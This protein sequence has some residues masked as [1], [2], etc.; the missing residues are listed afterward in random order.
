MLLISCVSD[1]VKV[2]LCIISPPSTAKCIS[3]AGQDP[4][5]QL[6]CKGEGTAEVLAKQRPSIFGSGNIK[7]TLLKVYFITDMN[8][9]HLLA[10]S[11]NEILICDPGA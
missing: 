10:S 11:N 6:D 3:V 4:S 9:N 2:F 7:I 8:E 1:I 5:L